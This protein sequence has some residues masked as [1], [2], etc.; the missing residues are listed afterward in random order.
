MKSFSKFLPTLFRMAMLSTLVFACHKDD[1]VT[2]TI[3]TPSTV[4]AI[5]PVQGPKGTPVS[6]AGTN[7]GTDQTKISVTINDKPAT[8]TSVTNS[9]IT[10]M[11]PDR[12]G[13]GKVAVTLNGKVLVDQPEFTYQLSVSTLAG[14]GTKGD[15]DGDDA[16]F[17]APAGVFVDPKSDKVYVVDTENSKIKWITPDGSVTKLVGT[18]YGLTDGTKDKAAFLFPNAG[19]MDNDGNIYIADEYNYAIRKIDKD[20][21][22]TTVAG[23]TPGDTDGKGKY[24]FQNPSGVAIDKNGLLYVADQFNNKIKTVTLDGDVKTFAGTGAAGAQDGPGTTATFNRPVG[25]AIDKDGNI[26]VGDLFNH[27]IR[28]ITPAGVVSTLA[29][30]GASG[31]ADGKGTAAKFNFPAGLAIDAKGILYVAD[32]DNHRVR[33]VDTNGNVSTL[34]GSTSGYLDGLTGTALFKSPREIDINSDGTIY[35]VDSGDNRIR[36]ID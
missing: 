11:V 34:T 22:T 18:S 1:E 4:V 5:S 33:M 24:S 15:Q 16:E 26:Y 29:G 27:L 3:T 12:A 20:G 36:K 32:S 10:V 30:S 7:F 14:N 8:I 35:V 19:V 21:Y 2:P 9:F 25:I 28:K 6:I 31:F 17:A 23:G 13:S